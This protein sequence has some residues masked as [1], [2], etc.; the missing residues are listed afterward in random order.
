M[1]AKRQMLPQEAPKAPD[2]AAVVRRMRAESLLRNS[3]GE[4]KSFP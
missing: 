2:I 4:V 3:R 1:A